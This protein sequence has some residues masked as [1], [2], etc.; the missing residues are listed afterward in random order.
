[1]YMSGNCCAVTCTHVKM[2]RQLHGIR[3]IPFIQ[4]FC[5]TFAVQSR[6]S[7]NLDK[8]VQILARGGSM[9]I[10]AMGDLGIPWAALCHES[11]GL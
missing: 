10:R 2:T 5:C 11:H 3:A 9:Q 8:S 6:A 4:G 7:S 1:M